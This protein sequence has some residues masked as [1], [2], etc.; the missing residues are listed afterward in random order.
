LAKRKSPLEGLERLKIS[1]IMLT[2]NRETLVGRAIES[3]L[4]QTLADF[5]FIIVDNGSTD[6]SGAIAGEYAAR[7]SRIRLVRLERGNIGRGR[8][9]GLDAAKG[10]CIAFIDDDDWCEADFLEF[11][12][13]LMVQNGADV[14]VCGSNKHED[15]IVSANEGCV[16]DETYVMDAEKATEMYLWRKLFNAAMPC[17][18]IKRG[19]FEKIRFSS[20][21]VYDDISTTYK[22]FANSARVAAHGLPKYTFRRH[23]GNNSSAATKHELLNPGQLKEYLAA[24]RERTEYI[25]A[26][27]PNLRPLARYSE[28]SYMISMIE[29][30][31]RHQLKNCRGPLE[32]MRGEIKTNIDEFLNGGFVMDYEREWLER[33]L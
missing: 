24:F 33:W 2:C 29:K 5:E 10:E 7:D 16:Y 23:D 4:G 19:L 8:N 21:G 25:S 3:V 17:K 11:L 28:W 15:G 12:H 9:A 18:L 30:I 1:V 26:V 13:E 6:Q 22:Y 20:E 31:N 14:S 32:F 27:L